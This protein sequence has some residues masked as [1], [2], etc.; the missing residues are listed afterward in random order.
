MIRLAFQLKQLKN[1]RIIIS[2]FISFLV[3]VTWLKYC[4]YGVKLY[5]VFQSI[6]HFLLAPRKFTLFAQGCFLPNFIKINSMVLKNKI[7]ECNLICIFT[8]TLFTPLEHS[9][10]KKIIKC[11][12]YSLSISQLSETW[13]LIWTNLNLLPKRKF[14]PSFVEI[15]VVILENKISWCHQCIFTMLS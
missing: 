7:F 14:V 4:L 1:Q 10:E 13:P 15:G 3:A 6:S 8:M 11:H 5:T 12:Q 9:L 2:F